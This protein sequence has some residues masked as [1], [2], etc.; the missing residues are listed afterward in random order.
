VPRFLALALLLIAAAS[1]APASAGTSS[2]VKVD[3]YLQASRGRPLRLLPFMRAL[4]KGADLHTHLSGSV[5]AESL[6]SWAAMDGLCID[7]LTYT[8]SFPPCVAGQVPASNAIFNNDFYN[9]VV[10]AWSMKDFTPGIESSHDHF[11]ATFAKIGAANSS[12]KGDALAEVAARASSQNEQYLETMFS[13]QSSSVAKIGNSVG[14]SSD[15]AATRSALLA[16]GMAD[17][18]AAARQDLDAMMAQ[19]NAALGCGTAN[20]QPACTMPVG[21][22]CQ[23]PRGNPPQVVYAQMVSCFELMK[24]DPRMVA[25]NLVAPEDGVVALRDYRLHMS[26]LDY[27]HGVYPTEHITLHAGELVPGLAPPADLRFHI[28]LAIQQG[29]AERI[30]HG[31]DIRSESRPVALMRSMAR[32]RTAVEV[33]LTSN[34]QV[35]GLTGGQ[36]QFPLYRRYGVPVVLATDD[37]GVER[38]DLTEEY[39]LAFKQYHLHY[40]DLRKISR[41]SLRCAFLPAGKKAQLMRRLNAAFRLFEARFG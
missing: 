34:E 11:F 33:A 31:S 29:H 7:S 17:I 6:V 25:V 39:V 22:Q 13:E 2:A 20:A 23:V 16:G 32:K 37:E 19:F 8:S 18:V 5:Y 27:L 1:P 4:P 24:A 26:M 30:G 28:R 21:F 41:D 38:T 36:S 35:L 14:L 9:Q 3:R 12:H 40:Q 10:A 15:L